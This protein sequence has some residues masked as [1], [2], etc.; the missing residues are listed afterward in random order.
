MTGLPKDSASETQPISVVTAPAKLTLSL[1]VVGVRNDGFHL[2]DAEMTTLALCDT[3][4]ID[5]QGIATI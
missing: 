3:L 5:A 4:Q 2:I 1:H